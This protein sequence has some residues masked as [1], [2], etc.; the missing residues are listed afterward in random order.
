MN[1]RATYY[2]HRIEFSSI[3][4]VGSKCY[5][6]KL[7]DSGVEVVTPKSICR[8][9]NVATRSVYV[10]TEVFQRCYNEAVARRPHTPTQEVL[11][12]DD[13]AWTDSH[14]IEYDK[15]VADWKESLVFNSPYDGYM[16]TD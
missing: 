8:H 9:L 5:A 1:N 12:F 7:A 10:H 3:R 6:I 14:S 4:K 13:D 16:I 15:F 11:Q 2:H